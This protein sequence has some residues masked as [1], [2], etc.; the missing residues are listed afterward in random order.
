MKSMKLFSWFEF[1]P[2]LL[3]PF[4]FLADSEIHNHAVRLSCQI[5]ITIS[6]TVAFFIGLFY[7]DFSRNQA[8]FMA[9]VI[10]FVLIALKKI[11]V[12]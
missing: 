5:A 10:W 4:V 1:I 9:I 6:T 2:F 12:P 3:I 7:Y 8:L 11:Y